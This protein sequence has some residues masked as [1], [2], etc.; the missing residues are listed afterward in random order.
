M[1]FLQYNNITITK[2]NGRSLLNENKIEF[3]F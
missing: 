1:E 3:S 2:Q